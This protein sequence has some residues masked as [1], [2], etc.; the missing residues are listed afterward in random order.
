MRLFGML[1]L[2]ALCW[3]APAAAQPR[4]FVLDSDTANEMDDMYAIAQ[5]VLDPDARLLGLGSAHFNN[6]ELYTR[7]RWHHYPMDGFVPVEASQRENERLLAL[8]G[9]KLPAP[10]GARDIIGFSWGYFDGAPIPEAA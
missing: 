6:V 7:K 3:T 9:A 8:L 2:L 10:L 5:A 1:A 4:A